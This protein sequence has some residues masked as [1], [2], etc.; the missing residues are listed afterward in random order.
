MPSKA[1]STRADAKV[2]AK[3]VRRN[4]ARPRV[5]KP[6]MTKIEAERLAHFKA[7]MLRTGGKC[8]F[9]GFDE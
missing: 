4:G 9:A 2:A 6:R 1:A 8:Q 5:K 3:A 7:L